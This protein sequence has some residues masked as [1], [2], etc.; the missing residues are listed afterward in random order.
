MENPELDS[1]TLNHR[2]KMM[3]REY[4]KTIAPSRWKSW[5]WAKD[6]FQVSADWLQKHPDHIRKGSYIS[7][8][9]G[10][11]VWQ[12]QLPQSLGGNF[13]VYKFFDFSRDDLLNRFGFS[14]AYYDA[15]N[16]AFLRGIGIQTPEIL[17]CGEMR[18][19]GFVKSAY[20]VM[21]FIE[22]V[23]DGSILTPTGSLTDN[24]RIRMGFGYKV[25]EYFAKLHLSGFSQGHFHSHAVL[26][27]KSCD[28][29]NPTLIWTDVASCKMHS[30]LHSKKAIPRDLVHFFVDLRYDTAQIH[31][32]CEH[33]LKYN[34][35]SGYNVS[36]LWK[37][38]LAIK[39]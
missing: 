20:V 26:I 19:F 13:I 18:Q 36:S 39:H 2:G 32:L 28:E 24:F 5:D 29:D 12:V 37:E 7:H 11:E 17:A 34:N 27:P 33:Y 25:M 8:T 31:T 4:I 15:T 10:K 21:E 16:S 9:L 23:Y 35:R 14:A 1:R 3:M 38:M 22:D 6:G 30:H